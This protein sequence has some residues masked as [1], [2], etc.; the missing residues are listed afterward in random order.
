MCVVGGCNSITC[1]QATHISS[2]TWRRVID[3]LASSIDGV[4]S[5]LPTLGDFRLTKLESSNSLS[6]VV[7]INKLSR[8][9]SS[10]GLN[11]M[12]AT[13]NRAEKV[14][15]FTVRAFEQSNKQTPSLRQNLRKLGQPN[16]RGRFLIQ[17]F[18]INLPQR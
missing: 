7:Q 11:L 14:Y 5:L 4:I 8:D 2:L 15:H 10:L 16:S 18:K 12:A 3:G 1:N 9:F 6:N 17:A 13:R